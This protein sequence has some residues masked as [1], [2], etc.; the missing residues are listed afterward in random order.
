MGFFSTILEKLGIN[1]AKAAPVAPA[2]T[3]AAPAPAANAARRACARNNRQCHVAPF[4]PFLTGAAK[5]RNA[6]AGRNLGRV[7]S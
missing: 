3:A 2:P 4:C 1:E 6:G 5:S 7:P